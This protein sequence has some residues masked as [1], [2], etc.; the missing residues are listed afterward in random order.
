[1]LILLP[2]SEGKTPG[3][4]AERLDLGT[5]SWPQLTP[6]REQVLHALTA[7]CRRHPARARQLLGLSPALDADRVANAEIDT[8]PTMPAGYRYA[9]VLHEALGY[10]TLTTAARRRADASLVVF[11]GLWG[12]VRPSDLLPAYRIGIA[13]VL[14]RIGPLPA[15]WRSALHEALDDEVARHG[16]LDLR[17][18]G[19]SQMYR[20]SAAAADGIVA[21]RITGPDGKRSASSYQSKVAKGRLVRAL[22]QRRAP[23]RS[24]VAGAAES[25]GL[26]AEE[27]GSALLVKAPEG[28]GLV[29]AG[30][31]SPR[32]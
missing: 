28:W 30:S 12:V 11:S 26:V 3:G 27:R 32:T 14:P 6:Q 13:T 19:Y 18:S 1:V 31:Q 21:A 8:A 2:P 16:A 4:H 20:P 22:V 25:I 15:F 23:T 17:S 10:P 24:D 9:G 5:L 29:G 7:V